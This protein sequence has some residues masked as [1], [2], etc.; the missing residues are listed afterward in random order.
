MKHKNPVLLAAPVMYN[1]L[2]ASTR[3]PLPVHL[4]VLKLISYFRSHLVICHLFPD[5][6]RET[7]TVAGMYGTQQSMQQSHRNDVTSC[8]DI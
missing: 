5:Y 3:I 7:A 1:I 4:P 8:Q 6:V 2:Y